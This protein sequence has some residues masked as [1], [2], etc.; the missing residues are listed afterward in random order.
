TLLVSRSG[1]RSLSIE[2]SWV[3]TQWCTCRATDSGAVHIESNSSF[4]Q[5]LE[6]CGENWRICDQRN[7]EIVL[8]AGPKRVSGSDDDIGVVDE[9]LSP[10]LRAEPRG[11]RQPHEHRAV[12]RLALP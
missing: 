9:V 12:R 11:D 1:F 7:A 8:A 2:S 4:P 5:T 10:F 6:R 3:E